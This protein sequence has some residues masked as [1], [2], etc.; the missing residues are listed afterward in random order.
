[1][2]RKRKFILCGAVLLV[3]AVVCLVL[4]CGYRADGLEDRSCQT[5]QLLASRKWGVAEPAQTL[6]ESPEGF[7]LSTR[8]PLAGT[9]RVQSAGQYRI[10]ACYKT[11]NETFM[12]HSLTLGLGEDSYTASLP[13][14]WSENA[15]QRPLDRYGDEMNVRAELTA[16]AVSAPLIRNNDVAES[17]LTVTLEAGELAY[18]LTGSQPVRIYGLYLVDMNSSPAQLAVS[19]Q[20]GAGGNIVVV[21]AENLA[22]K[23]DSNIRGKNVKNAALSPY[24]TQQEKI[25][26]LDA[27]AWTDVGQKI[28]W[29]ARVEEAGWYRVGFRYSQYSEANKFSYRTLEV[30]GIPLT[31]EPVAFPSTGMNAYRNLTVTQNGEDLWV[32][33]EA[34]EHTIAMQAVMDPLLEPYRELLEIMQD[35]NAIS[36]DLRKLTAGSSDENRTWDMDQYMPQVPARLESYRGRIQAVYQMLWQIQGVEPAY[37]NQ[38]LQAVQQLDNL[39]EDKRLIPNKAGLLSEGD[40]SVNSALGEVLEK[41]VRHPLSLDRIYL[42]QNTQ[43]PDSSCSMLVTMSE[44]LKRLGATYLPGAD[45]ADYTAAQT[46]SEELQVWVN[47]SVSYAE[48]LQQM[49]DETYNA[50]NGTKITICL[51]PNEQKLILSNA[52]DSNP[53]VVLGV[54]FY[55]P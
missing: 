51:M 16:Y 7:L 47:M 26:V 42:Y 14:V 36:M 32:Y 25:N 33:L 48:V 19:A 35:I 17:S 54:N 55:T 34:G 22:L 39:L 2:D 28:L 24:D 11:E 41:L 50:E 45:S 38:L 6:Y 5:S 46:D 10:W 21:E 8:Q 53:D 20:P 12:E 40:G 9:V 18:S 29:V 52:T 23:S 13:V 43:L 30:D 37:A 15:A 4:F 49:L 44:A 31:R 27:N 3:A 1:M